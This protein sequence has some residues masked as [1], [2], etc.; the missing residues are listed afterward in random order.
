MTGK[1]L[2]FDKVSIIV[3][4]YNVEKYLDRCVKSIINQT[5]KNI[6]I[7]LIDDGSTDT[8]G[9]IADKYHYDTR[10]HIIHKENGGYGSVLQLAI[11]SI[12]TEYFLICD[13]DDYLEL[14]AVEELFNCARK[15]DADIVVGRK[16]IIITNNDSVYNKNDIENLYDNYRNLKTDKS[17]TNLI[18]FI[19][20]P[21]SPHS[22]LFRTSLARDI[23]FPTKVSNTDY[24]LYIITLSK[25]SKAVYLDKKLSNYLID[26]PGN[27]F[28]DDE[29]LSDKAIE[30]QVKVTEEI[31][32]QLDYAQEISGYIGV[33]LALRCRVW[34]NKI[35]MSANKKQDY[36]DRL[37][38]CI[39]K[40]IFSKKF[41]SKFFDEIFYKI[42][43]LG[44]AY[45]KILMCL[46][47]NK[48]SRYFVVKIDEITRKIKMRN[49]S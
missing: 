22:K 14:N 17:Y 38:S 29:V 33:S 7:W 43:N 10:V 20:I 24:L 42:T 6:D 9:S 45:R 37:D 27:T 12:Q 47:Y 2:D 13:S 5:Y 32:S 11:S 49:H 44:K 30:S 41:I 46:F 1:V 39:D 25:C 28:N 48:K 8:S 16:N 34:I 26:R 35:R 19:S 4:I 15:H 40:L 31:I 36:L 23:E 18:P 21:P 3:P